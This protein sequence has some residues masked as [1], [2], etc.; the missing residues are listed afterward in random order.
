MNTRNLIS[1]LVAQICENNFSD[2]KKTLDTVVTE[3]VKTRIKN[4]IKKQ[5][6]DKKDKSKCDYTKTK[7]NLAKK[8]VGKSK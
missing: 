2:A 4:T 3:K 7:K 8:V 6:P 1:K 5:S